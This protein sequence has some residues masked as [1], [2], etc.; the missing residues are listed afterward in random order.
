MS[1]QSM[2]DAAKLFASNGIPVIPLHTPRGDGTCSCGKSDCENNGKHP[3]YNSGDLTNGIKNA[4]TDVEQINTWWERWPNANIGIAT[5][6]ASGIVVADL[7]GEEGLVSAKN[8]LGNDLL[9]N[10]LTARTGNGGAHLYFKTTDK[11]PNG[12]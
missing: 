12:V 9:E 4:T 6:G 11:L 3:R 1:R 8:L 5:G 2:K 10:T 7:D